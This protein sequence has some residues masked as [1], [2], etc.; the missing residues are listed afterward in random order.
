LLDSLEEERKGGLTIDIIQTPFES[1][2]YRYT[3]IDCPG[4]REFIKKMLT[5]VSQADAAVL[6][7]SA[8][9]G[10]EDQTRQHAFLAKTL[11]IGQLVVAI[12]KMDLVHYQGDV[13]AETCRIIDGILE[14]IGFRNV[15]KVPISAFNGDNVFET[16]QN[17]R[18]YNG[19]TLIDTLDNIVKP[20]RLPSEKPL[21]GCIQDVYKVDEKEIVVCRVETGTLK[22]GRTVCF[23]PSGKSGIVRT[24]EMLGSQLEKSM[25][26]DSVG[27][28]MDGVQ[29]VERGEVLSYPENPAKKA[30]SFTA[31]VIMFSEIGIK[32]GETHIVRVGTAEKKCRAS[33]I[34]TE[35]DPVSLTVLARSP[36]TLRGGYVGEVSFSP[37]EP[38]SIE[39]HSDFPSL[40]RFVIEG[41]K[42]PIGAGIVLDVKRDRF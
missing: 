21:R 10:V 34:L 11:G 32:N 27:L 22:V 41:K 42:G 1:K 29:D 40:G 25:P 13:F 37:L 19:T 38:L 9:E 36:D 15:P 2:K 14:S 30:K 12:N 26:G 33:E 5:G 4:H 24:I 8:K 31:E 18:W 7:L 39:K 17:M 35:I 28:V 16:S 6:V 23:S 20:V 3:I